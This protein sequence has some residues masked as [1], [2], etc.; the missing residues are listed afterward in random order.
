MVNSNNKLKHKNSKEAFYKSLFTHLKIS[1]NVFSF[2]RKLLGFNL[3]LPKKIAI[4]S[5]A[6]FVFLICYFAF[7][8]FVSWQQENLA[9]AGVGFQRVDSYIPFSQESYLQYEKVFKVALPRGSKGKVIITKTVARNN[10]IDAFRHAYVSGV[11]AMKYGNTVAKILGNLKES[12]DDIFYNQSKQEKAMDYWNN[13][14]GRRYGIMVKS[15]GNLAKI[16]KESIAK[17]ELVVEIDDYRCYIVN[18]H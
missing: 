17:R 5:F 15:R 12:Y 11:F 2:T 7:N 16:L 9:L 1:G 4:F 3:S 13:A 8:R 18:Q 14:I 6:T 10:Q